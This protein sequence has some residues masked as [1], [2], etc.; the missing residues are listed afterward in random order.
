MGRLFRACFLTSM[1]LMSL[2][3][4][5]AHSETSTI[6]EFPVAP[7]THPHDVAPAPDGIAGDAAK[8]G[9]GL[10]GCVPVRGEGGVLPLAAG[11]APRGVVTGPGGAPGITGGGLK[12]IVRVD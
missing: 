2:L 8:H 6:E 10:G 3:A 12:A 11:S 5:V 1:L 4:V 9:G 7:G